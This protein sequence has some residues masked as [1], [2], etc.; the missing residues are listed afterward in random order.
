MSGFSIL[1]TNRLHG[2]EI[3]DVPFE[4]GQEAE[5]ESLIEDYPDTLPITEINP[6]AKIAVPNGRHEFLRSPVYRRHG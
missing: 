3:V 1:E 5:L 6:T 4:S 2:T